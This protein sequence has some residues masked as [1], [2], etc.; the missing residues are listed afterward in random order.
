[1][2]IQRSSLRT[3]PLAKV[4]QV[5]YN[6]N[7]QNKMED[8]KQKSR[9][10][11]LKVLDLIYAAQTS[12]I[13]CNYSCIDIMTVLFDKID[14]DKD[15]FILGKGWSAAALYYF[16]YKKGRLTLKELNSYCKD[17][18]KYIGLAEPVHKDIPFAGGSIGMGIAAGVGYAMSKKL[19][20]EEGNVYVLE[21]DGGFQCGINWEAMMIAA[22]HK[23][24]NL[25]ILVDNNG[26]QGMGKTNDILSSDDILRKLEAFGLY[27]SNHNGHNFEEIETVLDAVVAPKPSEWGKRPY[28]LVFDTIKGKGVSFMENNNLWHYLYV[29]A[30]DY[31]KAKEEIENG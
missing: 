9:E 26:Y 7:N 22:H 23:L 11:R 8:Y 19:K 5:W 29:D 12:H 4:K 28:A 16:L 10:A 30:K 17:G 6:L 31:A 14:L 15:K 13:G 1:M 2:A 21:G 24:D 18:S 25:I 3:Y 20:G 27:A